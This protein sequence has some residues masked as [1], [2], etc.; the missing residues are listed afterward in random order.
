M[1]VKP[2]KGTKR[3]AVRTRAKA[4]RKLVK[5]AKSTSA[6]SAKPNLNRPQYG[7]GR[8][9]DSI[10]A[11]PHVNRTT[12]AKQAKLSVNCVCKMFQGRRDTG[13]S[14]AVRVSK[15]LGISL[16]QLWKEID[17]IAVMRHKAGKSVDKDVLM[18]HDPS[19]KNLKEYIGNAVAEVVLMDRQPTEQPV[20]ILK[21][22]SLSLAQ[23]E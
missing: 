3:K 14:A 8:P 20:D 6:N 9:T 23:S 11:F 1:L 4:K 10:Q 7:P 22:L 16:D 2:V 21:S 15:V 12:L 19:I 13:L 5:G 17:R 18:M